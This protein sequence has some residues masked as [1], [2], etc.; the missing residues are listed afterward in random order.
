MIFR[1]YGLLYYS[2][3]IIIRLIDLVFRGKG[4]SSVLK[5]LYFFW[6]VD[7]SSLLLFKILNIDWYIVS[8]V[9]FIVLKID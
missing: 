8:L 9:Y 4:K 2:I 6:K 7:F 3:P 5:I 1:K